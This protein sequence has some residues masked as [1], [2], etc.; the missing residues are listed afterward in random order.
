MDFFTV[1]DRN[2]CRSA[3]LRDVLLPERVADKLAALQ[4]E[5]TWGHAGVWRILRLEP[6]PPKRPCHHAVDQI[7]EL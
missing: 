2:L 7:P 3:D 4:A 1:R 6:D 5:R